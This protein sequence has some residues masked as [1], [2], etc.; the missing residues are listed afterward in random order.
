MLLAN[1]EDA[2][3]ALEVTGDGMLRLDI[4]ALTRSLLCTCV[5]FACPL[6]L[7]QRHACMYREKIAGVCM[8]DSKRICSGSGINES[9]SKRSLSDHSSSSTGRAFSLLRR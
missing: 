6:L 7:S 1:K 9:T 5:M 3:K 4:A 8:N 2:G